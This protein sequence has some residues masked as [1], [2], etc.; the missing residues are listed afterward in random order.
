MALKHIVR[1][2][3]CVCLCA[4]TDMGLEVVE[5]IKSLPGTVCGGTGGACSEIKLDLDQHVEFF[6]RINC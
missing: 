5:C 4:Q 3:P 2:P 1:F 6:G